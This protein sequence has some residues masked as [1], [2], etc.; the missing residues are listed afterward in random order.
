MS[1]VDW[2]RGFNFTM[3]QKSPVPIEKQN[4]PLH[5]FALSR[6]LV[7]WTVMCTI[8]WYEVIFIWFFLCETI[9]RLKISF[10]FLVLKFNFQS[11]SR[12]IRSSLW[13]FYPTICS[14]QI[15]VSGKFLRIV[16]VVSVGVDD[17]VEAWVVTV[18]ARAVTGAKKHNN[19]FKHGAL[20]CVSF[21]HRQPKLSA[22]VDNKLQ[23]SYAFSSCLAL[24]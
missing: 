10:S 23:A 19:R 5:N 6:I 1:H 3:G 13:I 22:W 12:R 14:V 8:S 24:T 21:R 15:H 7:I 11:T 9:L 2:W 17:D 18:A 4:S 16:V 20:K